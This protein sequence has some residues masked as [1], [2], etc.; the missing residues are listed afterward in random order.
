M[1]LLTR[2]AVYGTAGGKPA[3][4]ARVGDNDVWLTETVKVPDRHIEGEIFQEDARRLV[5]EFFK[6]LIYGDEIELHNRFWLPDAKE[7]N[8]ARCQC[9]RALCFS[10]HGL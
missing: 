1:L 3:V 7:R 8:Q 9:L 5:D 4:V 10:Q 2:F 6:V